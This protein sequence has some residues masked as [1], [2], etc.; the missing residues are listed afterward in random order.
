MKYRIISYGG[1]NEPAQRGSKLLL[2]QLVQTKD[3]MHMGVPSQDLDVKLRML[4]R[5]KLSGREAHRAVH[6][7]G[8]AG[9]MRARPEVEKLLGNDDPELRLISLEVLTRHWH[10]NEHWETSR[11][12]LREDPD[13][14]CRI[15]GASS[16]EVLKRNT[17]DRKTL[18]VLAKIVRDEAEI[19]GVR[20]AAYSAMRGILHYDAREQMRLASK[21]MDL[22]KDADWEMVNTYAT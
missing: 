12:F 21:G 20:E 5:G 1:K 18:S 19:Q 8:R 10:L 3:E 2:M 15:Q 13:K 17:A 4:R 11:R 6:E 16:L 7:F 14:Y 9:F 22:K